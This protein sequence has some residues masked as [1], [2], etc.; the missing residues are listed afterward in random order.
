ME[1]RPFNKRASFLPFIDDLSYN[2]EIVHVKSDL[3][4]REKIMLEELTKTFKDSERVKCFLSAKDP[5]QVQQFNRYFSQFAGNKLQKKIAI[6]VN[7]GRCIEIA[8]IG[9]VSRVKL[10][11]LTKSD[12]GA[13]DFRAIFD[14]VRV[15]FL[16]DVFPMD[17]TVKNQTARFI[18]LVSLSD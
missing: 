3:D 15:L 7:E 16:E 6:E 4:Y 10:D 5:I 18:M 13:S 12:F 1:S 9:N 2:C 17:V 14:Y 8:G 11:F